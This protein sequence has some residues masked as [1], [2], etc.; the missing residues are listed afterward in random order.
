MP[1]LAHLIGM[2]VVA[3]MIMMGGHRMIIGSLLDSFQS[4]PPGKV[5]LE[6]R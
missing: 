3:V 1:S 6:I 5:V 4:M 2:M